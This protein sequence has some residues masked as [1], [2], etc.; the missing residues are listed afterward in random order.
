MCQSH[1][2]PDNSSKTTISPTTRFLLAGVQAYQ[3]FVSPFMSARCR[4]Y[5]TC[6]AY[7]RQA[8]LWHGA[9]RGSWLA[10]RRILSCHPWG[11]SG[12]DFVPVPLW[13]YHYDFVS[14]ATEVKVWCDD[15]QH[16]YRSRLNWL[17]AHS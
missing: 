7:A 17:L 10:S 6:S 1:R 12:I 13:R 14:D 4:Y 11:G 2:S 5:P 15:D 16:S 9:M 3:R 8:L